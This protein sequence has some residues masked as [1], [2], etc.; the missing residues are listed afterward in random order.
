LALAP[1]GI[2]SAIGSVAGF[3]VEGGRIVETLGE[4]ETGQQAALIAPDGYA[5]LV[6]TWRYA[7]APDAPR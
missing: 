6:L 3:A 5:P 1:L 4:L 2:A 7:P